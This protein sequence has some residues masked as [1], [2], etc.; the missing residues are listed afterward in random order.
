MVSRERKRWL[1]SRWLQEMEEGI[2]STWRTELDDKEFS[3]VDRWDQKYTYG[4]YRVCMDIIQAE[5]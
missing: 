5:L 2:S 4:A 1:L 3:L